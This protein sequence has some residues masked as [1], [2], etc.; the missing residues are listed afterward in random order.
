MKAARLTAGAR[1]MIRGMAKIPAVRLGIDLGGTKIHCLVIDRKGRTLGVSRAAT[2]ASRGYAAVVERIAEIAGEAIDDAGIRRRDLHA[3]GLGAPG[4]IDP[5]GGVIQLAPN[6]GWRSKPL[7]EDLGRELDLPVVLGNDVNFGALGEATYG[8][9]RKAASSFAA[10]VG[11]GLGGG[12]VLDGQVVNGRHGFAGEIGHIPAPFGQAR[13]GCGHLGCLETTASR[14]GLVRLIRQAAA[15]GKR[16]LLPAGVVRSGQLVKA[17]DAGCPASRAAMAEL[18]AALGWG[19]ATV[20]NVLDPEVY[21]IGGGVAE[22]F[23]K[24]LLAPLARAMTA[25]AVLFQRHRPVLRLA[26]LGDDAVAIG[27]AVASGEAR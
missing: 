11:T 24:R 26:E 27:A 23:G 14:T 17:Y 3:V 4:M 15:A 12:F 13:C 1:T 5:A 7:A 20:G 16:C 22:A 6:L 19:L 18:I 21:V 8:G 10:F 25:N 9:S 2:K